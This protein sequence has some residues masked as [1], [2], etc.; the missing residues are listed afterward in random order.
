LAIAFA[1]AWDESDGTGN[2]LIEV[3][4]R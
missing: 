2:L 3:T 4:R 1:S